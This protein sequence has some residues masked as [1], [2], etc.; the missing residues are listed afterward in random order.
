[1]NY[2]SKLRKKSKNV[3]SF[4]VFFAIRMYVSHAYMGSGSAE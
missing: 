4:L 2:L 3:N 1:M